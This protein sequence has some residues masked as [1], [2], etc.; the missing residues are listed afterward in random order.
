MHSRQFYVLHNRR[1]KGMGSVADG[2][3]LALCGMVQE[4]VDENGTVRGH[5]HSSIHILGHAFFIIDHFHAPASQHIGGPY[6]H[7]I[8]NFLRDFKSLSHICRHT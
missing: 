3:G 1:H 4:T 6:H 8:A 2:I 5:A 7:R